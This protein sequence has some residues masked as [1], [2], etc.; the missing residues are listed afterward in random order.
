MKV[1]I[2]EQINRKKSDRLYFQFGYNASKVTDLRNP[3]NLACVA[4]VS[5]G[6]S[7]RSR[8][9]SHFD[10]A[11]IGANAT[12]MEAAGRGRGG[13]KNSDSEKNAPSENQ[14]VVFMRVT[15]K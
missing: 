11:N 6:F 12:P 1:H 10:G 8:Y 5:E 2:S 13:E 3:R 15:L 14:F 4:S 9:F 7:G